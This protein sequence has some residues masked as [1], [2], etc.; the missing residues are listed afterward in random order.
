[1]IDTTTPREARAATDL[2]LESNNLTNDMSGIQALAEALRVNAV[3][4][5]LDISFSNIGPKGGK[6]L[7]EALRVNAVLTTLDISNNELCGLD[8]LGRGT[9]DATG[10]K[11]LASALEVNAALNKCDMKL[12]KLGLEAQAALRDVVKGKEG[13]GI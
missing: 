1:L 5:T 3:L 10:V 4:T 2:N 12:N 8:S 13:T 11:A 7:T 9:Y 6:T